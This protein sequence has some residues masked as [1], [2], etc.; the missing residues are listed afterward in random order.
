MPVE[1]WKLLWVQQRSRVFA[2]RRS[3]PLLCQAGCIT[4]HAGKLCRNMC[5]SVHDPG[6]GCVCVCV[7]NCTP[8][9]APPVLSRKNTCQL[10][11]NTQPDRSPEDT[12]PCPRLSKV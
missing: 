9:L 8:Q 2:C 10:N 11:M 4:P 6:P 5:F 12:T 7:L 1:L 3:R